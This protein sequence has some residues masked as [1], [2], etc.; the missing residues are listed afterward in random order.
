[1]H[2][3]AV[4]EGVVMEAVR[5]ARSHGAGAVDH[6][7]VRLGALSG[8]EAAL[9]ERAFS[10]ARGGTLA[11]AATL[12]IEI[13]PIQVACAVCGACSEAAVNKIVCGSCGAWHVRVIGGE[14]AL[15]A[16][17]ELSG[18][19]DSEGSTEETDAAEPGCPRL[20]PVH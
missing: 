18:V 17:V 4:A 14:E 2:E 8:V 13:A 9:L 5:V 16:R 19:P 12:S 15:L 1:M 11:A 10:V 6:I 7:V 3:L 20:A